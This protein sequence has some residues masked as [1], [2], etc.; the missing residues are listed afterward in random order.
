ME[1]YRCGTPRGRDDV[2]TSVVGSQES[3]VG[4]GEVDCGEG[5][6][7]STVVLLSESSTGRCVFLLEG[8]VSDCS[9]M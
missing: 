5:S 6:T 4:P 7:I 8:M 3:G 2:G 1:T 9:G